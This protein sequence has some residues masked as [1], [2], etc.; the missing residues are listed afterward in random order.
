[1]YCI[2]L[3]SLWQVSPWGPRPVVFASSAG[4]KLR[5]PSSS[6]WLFTFWANHLGRQSKTWCLT[7]YH[8]LNV[9]IKTGQIAAGHLREGEQ[10][11]PQPPKLRFPSNDQLYY[12]DA[13]YLLEKSPMLQRYV[14]RGKNPPPSRWQV[15]VWCKMAEDVFGIVSM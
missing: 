6:R 12:S 9:R 11:R 8:S 1:M 10:G 15:M 14:V 13:S 3:G 4:S 2:Q 5:C 7:T